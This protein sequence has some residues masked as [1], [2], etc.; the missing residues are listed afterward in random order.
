MTEDQ[1]RQAFA[2]L[3]SKVDA[4]RHQSRPCSYCENI[5][6]T[7]VF[8]KAMFKAVKRDRV[9]YAAIMSMLTIRAFAC[10]TEEEK[11]LVNEM[12]Q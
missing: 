1:I 4:A 8:E 3:V 7:L 6:K 2:S 9:L 10:M 12:M 5:D 11:T